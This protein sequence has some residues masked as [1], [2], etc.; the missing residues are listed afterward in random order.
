MSYDCVRPF[1]ISQR[2]F[3]R[4][5]ELRDPKFE[6]SKQKHSKSVSNSAKRCDEKCRD[7]LLVS[8]K[9][10]EI[11]TLFE[12]MLLQSMLLEVANLGTLQL[13]LHSMQCIPKLCIQ[14]CTQFV[15]RNSVTEC[16]NILLQCLRTNYKLIGPLPRRRV[17]QEVTW[18]LAN[19]NLWIPLKH[20][21]SLLV[22]SYE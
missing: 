6:L 8:M 1:I 13:V 14:F 5:C 2:F 16:Y 15:Y 21:E 19:F 17:G 20:P 12:K 3:W 4:C 10:F 22:T 9:F 18:F 11:K 7:N